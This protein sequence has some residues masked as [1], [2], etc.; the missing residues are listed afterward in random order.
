MLLR[1]IT[2]HVSEQNWFAVVIDFAI[3]VI[4]VFIGIQVANWNDTRA[5]R[6]LRSQYLAQLKEDVQADVTEAQSTERQAW[7][8]VGAIVDVFE[9]AGIE[10]PLHEFY[11]E[12]QVASAPPYANFTSDYP[13]AHNHAITNLPTF[14]ETSETFNAIVSNGHFAL[15]EEPVLVR[16]LQAYQRQIEGVHGFDKAIVETF[17]R[18]TDMRSRHGISVGG[19]TTLDDLAN[20]VRSDSQ[21]AAELETYFLNSGF[22]ATR[23][24]E[25]RLRAEAL[26]DSI[27]E[28]Q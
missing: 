7:A 20:A 15:L 8:R 12:G 11:A 21:L 9:K 14:E 5:D 3:V 6:S 25:L 2:Q 24:G 19:R 18:V 23:V 13:Y 17:R 28:A 27:E 1:R 4:G 16:Q 10:E 22:Q 26:I